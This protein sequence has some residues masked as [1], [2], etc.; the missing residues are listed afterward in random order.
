MKL[1][2]QSSDVLRNLYKNSDGVPFDELHI[3]EETFLSLLS[4]DFVAEPEGQFFDAG[5]EKICVHNGTVKITPS[6]K[7]Y[8]ENLADEIRQSKQLNRR[9]WI[10]TGIAILAVVKS[11]LPEIRAAAAWLL[12]LLTQQ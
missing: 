2:K 12:K 9:Y 11:F 10:T 1:D 6:G 7:A 3:T 5:R 8:I 4:Q